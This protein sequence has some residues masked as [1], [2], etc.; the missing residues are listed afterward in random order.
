MKKNIILLLAACLLCVG[1]AVADNRLMVSDVNVPQGGEATIEIGCEFDT[2]FTAFE[3]QIALPEGLSL[4]TDE[5]GYLI[6][7]R[8][9][10]T[11]HILTGN[12][13]PSN[14]NYKITC[15]SMENLSMPTS[16]ALLRVTLLADAS[17]TLGTSLDASITACEFTRTAD[18]QGESL[19]DVPF[20]VNITEFRTILDEASTTLPVAET[21]ANVRVK[22]TINADEWSTICLPFAMTEAQVK[23][24]FGDDVE[25]G[26][27]SSWSSEE[28]DEGAIVAINVGFTTV[29]EME[30]NHPYIIKVSEKVTEF[31]VDGVDIEPEEEPM[32]QVG[33]RAAERG[34]MHGTYVV[35]TVPEENLFLSGNKFWYSTGNTTTK[36]LRGY[37]EFRDVLDA[38]YDATDAGAR[39]TM[40]FGDGTTTGVHETMNYEFRTMNCYDLQGRRVVTPGKGLYI[41][42]GK[43]V[44]K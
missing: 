19:D 11:N 7:E 15:R 41:Y 37:F 32:I 38:Y 5:G 28:D 26:D 1:Q 30:A 42:N 6:V 2:E 9:F 23:A 3:L 12:L 20:T 44:T 24:S 25:L 36:G 29:S 10:D 4:K 14:G 27:F 33:K 17:L 43:K 21:N 16:G 8:T 13:L 35:T 22:R 39:I 31:T 18:S 40:T 34:W